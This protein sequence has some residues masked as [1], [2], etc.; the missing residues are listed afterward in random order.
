[1]A[2][3][4]AASAAALVIAPWAAIGF[5]GL[6]AYPALAR[7]ANLVEGRRSFTIGALGYSLG[8]SQGAALAIVMIALAGLLGSSLVVGRRG[9]DR[10]SFTLAIVASLLC[11]PIAWLHY[12]VLLAAPLAIY[13]SRLSSWWLVP[14]ALWV[15]TAI[16]GGAAQAPSLWQIGLAVSTPLLLVA[17]ITRRFGVPLGVEP[18]AEA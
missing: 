7:Y 8:A 13:R 4:S 1:L 16:N 5:R 17:G 18:V 9:D 2:A 10:L 11:A 6:G 15:C 12:F 14:L 3:L